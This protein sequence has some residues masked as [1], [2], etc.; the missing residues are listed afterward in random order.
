MTN[1]APYFVLTSVTKVKKKIYNADTCE[2][3]SERDSPGGSAL[4]TSKDLHGFEPQVE[5]Q[6]LLYFDVIYEGFTPSGREA[7]DRQT[8]GLHSY[9]SWLAHLRLL[10]GRQFF[11]LCLSIKCWSIKCWSAKC[12]LTKRR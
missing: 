9:K 3:D 1:G 11:I 2:T 5:L 8:L 6:A 10:F 7:F 12:F 4:Q